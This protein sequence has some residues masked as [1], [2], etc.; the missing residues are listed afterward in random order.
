MKHYTYRVMIEPDENKTFHAWVPGLPGCH[1]W[2]D[3]LEEVRR[4]ARDAIQAYLA[5]LAE[6]DEP[7]PEENGFEYFETLTETEIRQQG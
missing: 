4:N 6:G 2:G 1:T 5:N 3:S 7:I